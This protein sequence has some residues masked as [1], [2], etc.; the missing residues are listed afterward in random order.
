MNNYQRIGSISNAHVGRDFEDLAYQHLQNEEFQLQM[1]YPLLLGAG[2]HK[3]Q[4]CFDLGGFDCKGNPTIVECKSHTW[5]SSGKTPS[6]KITVWNEA[7]YYF[8]LAPTEYRKIFF[9][10]KDNHP[11]R[12]ETLG[13]YYIRRYRH[14]IPVDIEILE[15]DIELQQ[16]SLLSID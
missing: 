15:Y 3:N 6:A 4:H 7:M 14:L 5:T 10:L 16:A 9:I 11:Y 2:K 12:N 13:N 1:K 8:L